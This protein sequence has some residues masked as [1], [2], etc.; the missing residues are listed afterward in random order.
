MVSTEYQESVSISGG[1]LHWTRAETYEGTAT[2]AGENLE[3]WTAQVSALPNG[4]RVTSAMTGPPS[5]SQS[6][7]V[8]ALSNAS[9]VGAVAKGCYFFQSDCTSGSPTPK[10]SLVPDHS[11]SLVVGVGYDYSNKIRKSVGRG[12]TLLQQA[13]DQKQYATMWVQRLSARTVAGRSVTMSATASGNDA[14]AVLAF[15]VS[16]VA[17]MPTDIA[18]NVRASR[19]KLAVPTTTAPPVT[20]PPVTAPPVTAPPVTSPPT[21]IDPLSGYQSAYDTVMNDL[22][23]EITDG[24][25]N[26]VS[27]I[28]TDCQQVVTD[29]KSALSLPPTANATVNSDWAAWLNE[30][31]SGCQL[32][33]QGDQQVQQAA[34]DILNDEAQSQNVDPSAISAAGNLSVTGEGNRA[35]GVAKLE[36]AS[37]QLNTALL[38]AIQEW[39][40]NW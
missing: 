40:G 26:N 19:K 8:L 18:R 33:I 13:L 28:T 23:A 1:G 32:I 9:G 11:G 30:N 5:W 25:S 2:T 15:E 38:T 12:E 24:Q 35:Q 31:T 34:Q 37:S 29:A 16:P 20:A 3:V 39:N 36:V 14:W 10:L 22:E 6:L 17:G 27:G 21:T 7:T 4:L